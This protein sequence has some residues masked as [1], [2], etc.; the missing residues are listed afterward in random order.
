L[1]LASL[2]D[3][4]TH[5]PQDK[6]QVTDG[7]DDALQLDAERLIKGY[8]ADVYSP[9][10]LAS[11]SDPTIDDPALP[12]YV[13]E[14]IRGIAGRFIAAFYYRIRYSEDT[15]DTPGYAQN[16]YDEAMDMLNKVVRGEITLIDVEESPAT[17]VSLTNELFW[18]NDSTAE[19]PYFR[20]GMELG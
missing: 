5:L 18:P 19:G 4:N 15:L 12:G 9:V 13:P 11:W 7:N 20:M 10:T 3:I 16:L 2:F 8:L 6:L 14:Y 1:P 17:D